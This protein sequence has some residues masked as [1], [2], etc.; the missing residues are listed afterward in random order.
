MS[1]FSQLKW[2]LVQSSV[3]VQ[4]KKKKTITSEQDTPVVRLPSL[5]TETH[6]NDL[7]RS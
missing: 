2:I 6:L 7:E 5:S 4:L 3:V 1:Q